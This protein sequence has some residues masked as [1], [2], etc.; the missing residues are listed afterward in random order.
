MHAGKMDA[1]R[2]VSDCCGFMRRLVATQR[3]QYMKKSSWCLLFLLACVFALP[4]Y[5]TS[6]YKSAFEA[7]YPAAAGSRIDACALCHSS[8]PA[9]NS[10]GEAFKS[11][12]FDFKAIEAADSDG[13]GFA[14]LAEI[15]ALTFPGTAADNPNATSDPQS[16][17]CAGLSCQK[18]AFSL[19][20][21]TSMLGDI[22]LVG[23]S[24][25][26]LQVMAG[27]KM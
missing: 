13:D 23:L 10:Y 18:G 20:S 12:G 11:A 22:F 27:R 3:K 24:L 19:D 14:N 8:V 17:G 7:A 9:R 4:V 1:T 2:T 15:T 25:I 26:T 5:A 6:S 21:I 16:T